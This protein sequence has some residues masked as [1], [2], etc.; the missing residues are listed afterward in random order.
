[1]GPL[2]YD[3]KTDPLQ[4]HNLWDDP[5][6]AGV[7]SEMLERLAHQLI[8]LMDESPRALQSA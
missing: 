5:V 2:L 3:R 8:A 7:K 6:F 4:S 1:V